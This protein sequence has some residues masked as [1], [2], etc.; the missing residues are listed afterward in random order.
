M[1]NKLI[2]LG[3]IA[4][5]TI[6]IASVFVFGSSDNFHKNWIGKH[7]FFDKSAWIDKLGLPED[8]SE[9]EIWE[10][11][12]SKWE[13]W[14][15]KIKEKLGLPEDATDKEVQAALEEWKE[16]KDFNHKGFHNYNK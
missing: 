15:S 4:L 1:K 6:G 9:E 14:N 8:A 10:A 16:N 3:I 13:D 7:K 5:L 2:V 11:K 12:K